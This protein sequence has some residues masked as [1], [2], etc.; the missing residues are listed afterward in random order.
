MTIDDLFKL[1]NP[2][3]IRVLNMVTRALVKKIDATTKLQTIQ[4]EMLAGEVRDGLEHFQAYGFA[5]KA[6][7]PNQKGPEAIVLRVGGAGDHPVV[8]M[9]S[10]RRY[11]PPN[12]ESGEV[13]VYDAQ[14]SSFVLKANGDAVITPASGKCRIEA[15]LTVDG[16]ILATGDV[17]SQGTVTG[18]TDVVHGTISLK[19]HVHTVVATDS[20]MGPVVFAP[21]GQTLAPVS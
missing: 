12:L 15:D 4:V 18:D 19:N 20:V 1:L 8:I 11:L 16:K 13:A 17:H 2:L 9:V 14:R 5:S 6:G 10:D 7:V 3:R 21:V